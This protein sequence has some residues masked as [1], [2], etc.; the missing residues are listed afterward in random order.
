MSNKCNTTIYI[1]GYFN[2][3]S[4]NISRAAFETK[5]IIFVYNT[6]IWELPFDF[7]VI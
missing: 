1:G 6:K 2:F 7:T 5:I 4:S 3:Q